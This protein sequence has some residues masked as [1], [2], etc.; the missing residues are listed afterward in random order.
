MVPNQRFHNNQKK[1]FPV[2][3]R[4]SECPKG[5]FTFE[6][7]DRVQC[8]FVRNIKSISFEMRKVA[9][10]KCASDG[11]VDNIEWRETAIAGKILP[12]VELGCRTYNLFLSRSSWSTAETE[13]HQ[14]KQLHEVST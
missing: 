6:F 1:D 13:N 12:M 7:A 9:H 3:P 11:T 10:I 8:G 5:T 14:T 4:V 2:C